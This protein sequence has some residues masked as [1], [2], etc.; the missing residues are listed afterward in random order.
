MIFKTNTDRKQSL[1]DSAKNLEVSQTS[2]NASFLA[3]RLL[4]SVTGRSP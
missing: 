2:E 4:G 3:V 1:T